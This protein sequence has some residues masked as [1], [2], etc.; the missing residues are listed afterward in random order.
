MI[1][2]RCGGCGRLLGRFHGRGH[3]KCPKVLCGGMNVFDTEKR[4]YRFIPKQYEPENKNRKG[5]EGN[6]RL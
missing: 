3:V 4:E 1:E 5:G 6:G 2:V